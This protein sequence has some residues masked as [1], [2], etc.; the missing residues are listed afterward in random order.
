MAL[1]ARA[2]SRDVMSQKQRGEIVR[3][4]R[5]QV[6]DDCKVQGVAH[7]ASGTGT[8]VNSYL[9]AGAESCECRHNRCGGARELPDTGDA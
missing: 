4:K 9:R 1:I 3:S 8:S 2:S 5:L 7:G 6:G